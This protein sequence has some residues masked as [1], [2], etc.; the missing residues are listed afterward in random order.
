[1]AFLRH[2]LQ[3]LD[4]ILVVWDGLPA[5]RSKRVK[6]F[7]SEARGRV[8]LERLPGYAPELNPKEGIWKHLKGVELRNLCC[9]NLHDLK[10]HYR[11]ARERMRHNKKLIR[12]CFKM[13]GLV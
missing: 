7:L 9:H 10:Q 1:M 2:L 3:Y 13:A 5:H 8:H 4:W 12:G 6:Q 11:R